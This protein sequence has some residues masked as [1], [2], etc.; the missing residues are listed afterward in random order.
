MSDENTNLPA[1]STPAAEE[2]LTTKQRLIGA[3]LVIAI[4]FTI[5]NW[6]W[7]VEHYRGFFFNFGKSLTW[8]F[9]IFPVLGDIV[10]MI[11]IVVLIGLAFLFAPS[12]KR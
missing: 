12:E 6:L 5:Y 9:Q 1:T 11:F 7:G 8:P 3:Y 4:G 10:G 2:K